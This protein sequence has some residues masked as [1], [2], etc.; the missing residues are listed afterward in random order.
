MS[1]LRF[2]GIPNVRHCGICLPC[3]LRRTAIHHAGLWGYDTQYA[4]DILGDFGSIPQEG[5]TL[6]FQ[7]LEF[8]RSLEKEDME[9]L[10]EIPQFYI[11][12]IE[13][14]TK[15]ISVM[16]RYSEEVKLCLKD[17]ADPSLKS[18]MPYL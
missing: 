4:D 11:W 16:R 15:L 13:D 17:K 14:Q 12:E 18:K 6:L 3:L 9:I 1:R 8:G 5:K 2:R 7:V 10:A